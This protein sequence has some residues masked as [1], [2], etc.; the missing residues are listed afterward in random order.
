[1]RGSPCN[2]EPRRQQYCTNHMR[3][4]SRCA[5]GYAS[6][7]TT[8]LHAPCLQAKKRVFEIRRQADNGKASKGA[9]KRPLGQ[10]DPDTAKGE[11]AGPPLVLPVCCPGGKMQ[12]CCLWNN[13]LLAAGQGESFTAVA[14]LEEMPKWQVLMQVLQVRPLQHHCCM[15]RGVCSLVRCGNL[16]TDPVLSMLVP[17]RHLAAAARHS[18]WLVNPKQHH[19]QSSACSCLQLQLRMHAHTD[20]MG[21]RRCGRRPS[22]LPA[23]QILATQLRMDQ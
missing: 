19:Y 5:E 14:T 12:E 22:Q 20:A 16:H 13:K 7:Q 18:K 6:L 9:R 11:A 8:P 2:A 15:H 21:C 10:D 4:D 1:M 17:G 23:H 3:L